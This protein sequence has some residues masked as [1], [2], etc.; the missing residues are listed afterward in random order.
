M[1]KGDFG[2][3]WSSVGLAILLAVIGLACG[4][5]STKP[6]PRTKV[7]DFSLLDINPQS[8]THGQYVSLSSLAGQIVMIY[9]GAATCPECRGELEALSTAID[10]LS[11]EGIT[12]VTGM[13]IVSIPDQNPFDAEYLVG[14]A[15][16]L[17]VMRD[18]V[19]A[20]RGGSAVLRLID[21]EN[22]NEFLFI[23]RDG[24][25]WKKTTVG[26]LSHAAYDFRP[27]VSPSGYAQ[28]LAWLRQIDDL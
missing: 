5:G 10:S 12:G 6:K 17:P 11:Q 27:S 21:C 15:S 22:F 23:D 28:L 16:S 20:V 18:S 3:R 25:R 1:H 7:P 14:M 26:N 8:P 19:D 4:D 9:N 13:M 24:Y 2:Q